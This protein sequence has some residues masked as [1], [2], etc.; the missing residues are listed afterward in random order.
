[1]FRYNP[2][3]P[4][5]T[6][7]SDQELYDRQKEW[8][9]PIKDEIKYNYNKI[10]ELNKNF[11]VGDMDYCN[12]TFE[13]VATW[14]CNEGLHVIAGEGVYY[15]MIFI[16]FGALAI[17]FN[18]NT[19]FIKIELSYIFENNLLEKMKERIN[20]ESYIEMQQDFEK[21]KQHFLL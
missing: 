16:S 18:E 19:D 1:M 10:K 12:L 3:R 20:C 21:I 2:R 6:C 17:E 11:V 14:I 4:Y 13:D 5:I 8:K 9:E 15:L 7:E